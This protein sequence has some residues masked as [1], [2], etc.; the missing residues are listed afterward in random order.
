MVS[1]RFDP[2]IPLSL[3]PSRLE[4]N[5]PAPPRRP[6][7]GLGTAMEGKPRGGLLLWD[8]KVGRVPSQGGSEEP[9]GWVL[10]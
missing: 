6:P 5:T 3:A 4:L 9:A 1:F 7:L 2:A 8:L 10:V